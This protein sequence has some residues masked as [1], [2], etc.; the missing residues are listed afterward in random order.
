MVLAMMDITVCLILCVLTSSITVDAMLDVRA[1]QSSS[2]QKSSQGR[3]GY[4]ESEQVNLGLRDLPF[5]WPQVSEQSWP[6]YI[7]GP[8][9]YK[10]FFL[11]KYAPAS[12]VAWTGF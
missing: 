8:D 10:Y 2:L 11:G 4:Q 7:V 12:L 3:Q 6:D 1:N 5:H 9:N